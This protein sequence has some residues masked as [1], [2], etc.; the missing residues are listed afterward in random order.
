MKGVSR[1]NGGFTLIEMLVVIAI[2]AMLSAIAIP[3]FRKTR[4]N[5]TGAVCLSNQRQLAIAWALYY[6]D[7]N[8]LLVGGSNYYDRDNST[9]W[10]WVEQPLFTDTDNPE[11]NPVPDENLFCQEFRLNG[12]RAGELFPYTQTE[13][14]YHCPGD[15]THVKLDEPYALWRSYE[16]AG[17]MNGEDF[18]Y[19]KGDIYSDIS[20]YSYLEYPDENKTL[21]CVTRYNQIQSPAKKYVFVE[22]SIAGDETYMLGSFFLMGEALE[23]GWG[24]WPADTHNNR[25]TLAF[26]DGHVEKHHWTDPRTFKLIKNGWGAVN[27]GDVS[28]DQP[29]NQ[30]LEWMVS[31]YI[32]AP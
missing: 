22:E 7:H 30:D 29:G 18:V 20:D 11:F 1:D 28:L 16:I 10:R 25:S 19:R 3:S 26:A 32:P 13:E 17:L 4:Q 15:R 2:I 23:T 31:G 6:D 21:L 14:I 9:P 8:G 24:N 5:A 12:I 27:S